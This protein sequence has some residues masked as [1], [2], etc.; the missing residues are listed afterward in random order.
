ME[1]ELRNS[2]NRPAG[3]RR[4]W[5]GIVGAMALIALAGAGE[6]SAATR[7]LDF[8]AGVC[9]KTDCG[10]SGAID[11]SYGSGSGVKVSYRTVNTSNGGTITDQLHFWRSEYGDLTNVA[12]GGADNSR[13]SAEIILTALP[14]FELSL[15]SLDLATFKERTGSAPLSIRTLGG[16][17]LFSQTVSTNPGSHNHLTFDVG[18]VTDGIILAWGPDSYNVGMDNITFDVR[19]LASAVPEPGAWALML[20]GFGLAGSALRRSLRVAGTGRLAA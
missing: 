13:F 20:L 16:E 15:Q 10:T 18:P 5:N 9:G 4:R 11:R 3:K 2:L 1:V 17:I 8:G 19:P 12:Y 6:A 7:V 14:G